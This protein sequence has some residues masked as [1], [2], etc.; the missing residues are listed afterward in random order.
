L[1]L[2][3][4]ADH[5]S[6]ISNRNHNQQSAISNQQ[7]TISNQS[8]N[9]QSANQQISGALMSP[10]DDFDG[11]LPA[12]W[13][14]V[15]LVLRSERAHH[16]AADRLVNLIAQMRANGFDRM[17]FARRTFRAALVL[18]RSTSADLGARDPMIVFVLQH[19][20]IVSL[21]GTT[22]AFRCCEIS[23]GS[24]STQ[25]TSELMKLADGATWS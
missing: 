20:R 12:S 14:F 2:V 8:A 4:F 15:E 5:H 7:S 21:I 25:L 1:S 10:A 6:A 24:L 3:I 11:Y 22:E 18:T 9:Q 19:D 17:L 13:D 23:N 16:R